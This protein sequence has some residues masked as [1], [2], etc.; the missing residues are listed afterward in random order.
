MLGSAPVTS[1]RRPSSRSATSRTSRTMTLR[2]DAAALGMEGIS[3]Q[4]HLQPVWTAR[5]QDQEPNAQEL[6]PARCLTAQIRSPPTTMHKKAPS[7]V[8]SASIVKFALVFPILI[9]MLIAI[10]DL[11]R[12]VF[13][14]NDITNAARQGARPAI[15]DQTGANH[16]ERDRLTGDFPG[17]CCRAQWMSIFQAEDRSGPC[18][19][20]KD[21]RLCRRGE[22][23][24]TT[25][26]R[27]PRSSA[28]S[29]DR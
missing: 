17:D 29:S 3:F 10:F 25:G 6:H 9:V 12:A 16:P 23:S 2:A 26:K 24:P 22:G 5:V 4:R 14:Y 21:P 13:A 19:E 7:S 20:H 11:G 1:L 15:I 27:S 18:L 8:A 28:T